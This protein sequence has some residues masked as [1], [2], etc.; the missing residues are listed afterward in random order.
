M[1]AGG[2][3]VLEDRRHCRQ[4]ARLILRAV[5][6]GWPVSQERR[7]QIVRRL[8]EVIQQAKDARVVALCAKV[9]V[10]MDRRELRAVKAAVALVKAQQAAEARQRGKASDRE[11]ADGDGE[12]AG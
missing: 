5:R 2:L 7:P 9:F 4:D 6:E 8:A 11:Q 10:E 1:Q 12:R 3:A